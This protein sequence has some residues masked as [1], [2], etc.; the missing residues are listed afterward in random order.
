MRLESTL[1]S[2]TEFC[3]ATVGRLGKTIRSF[4]KQLFTYPKF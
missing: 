1:N 2:I 3:P 4:G